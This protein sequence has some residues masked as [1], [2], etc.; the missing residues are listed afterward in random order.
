MKMLATITALF[1]TLG[2]LGATAGAETKLTV[3]VLTASSQ[4]FLV[5]STLIEGEKDAVLID[6]QFT[7]A[8]AHRVVAAILD[9]KKNLTTVYLTHA[10]PDHYFGLVAIKQAFPAAKIVALPAT[11]AEIK[12]TWKGK[13]AQWQP[14]F[15]ANLASHPIVPG[16]LA[17]KTILLE[18]QALEIHG[19]VQGDERQSSYV[20]IPSIKT[21]IAG[22]IVYQGVHPWTA[23]TDAAGRKAWRATLAELSALHPSVV[24]AGH[25]DPKAKDDLS[26]VEATRAYLEAFDEAVASSKSGDEAERKIK[27]RYPNLTLDVIA[28]FGAAAQF[29]PKQ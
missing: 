22:D 6:G 19:G 9:S 26:G 21:V 12:K 23:E 3:H 7:L 16:P 11:V 28:H 17:D 13:L 10:H 2:A 29:A 18:G 8:D 1:L 5:D 24:V 25:K 20:W 14:L 27:A 4:G 15:G